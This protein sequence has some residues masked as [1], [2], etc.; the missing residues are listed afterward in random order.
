MLRAGLPSAYMK[1]TDADAAA[2]IELWAEM[3]A[4]TPASLVFAAA[5]TYIWN[6]NDGKF[7][8]PGAI[9]EEINTIRNVVNQ[10]ADGITVKEYMGEASER[11]PP[12]VLAFMDKG[13]RAKHQQIYG[14]PF[15]SRMDQVAAYMEQKALTNGGESGE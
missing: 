10:C 12:A 7:P 15:M 8:T 4:E 5:K 9:R 13:Y 11:F 3:F 14:K 2:M 1:L 6:N